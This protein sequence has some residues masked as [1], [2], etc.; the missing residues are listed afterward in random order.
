MSRLAAH[1]NSVNL[2]S[3]GSSILAV[4]H[5]LLWRALIEWSTIARHDFLLPQILSDGEE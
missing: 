5:V 4:L 2:K 1:I 3:N